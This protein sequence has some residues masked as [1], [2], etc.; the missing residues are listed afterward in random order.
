MIRTRIWPF[1]PQVHHLAFSFNL[2]DRTESLFLECQVFVVKHSNSSVDIIIVMKV[3]NLRLCIISLTYMLIF[4]Y[5]FIVITVSYAC[6]Y[7]GYIK[8]PHLLFSLFS[9]TS[10]YDSNMN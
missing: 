8:Y 5:S 1:S 4:L 9:G 7:D 10:F 2:L 6:N 3:G